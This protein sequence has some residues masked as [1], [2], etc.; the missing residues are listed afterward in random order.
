MNINDYWQ[1]LSP[2]KNEVGSRVKLKAKQDSISFR[3]IAAAII[4]YLGNW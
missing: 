3:C 1:R 2:G 4:S